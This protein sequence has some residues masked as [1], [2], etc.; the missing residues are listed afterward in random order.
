MQSENVCD[1]QWLQ[2]CGALPSAPPSGPPQPSE[3]FPCGS[4]PWH[5]VADLMMMMMDT[6][7]REAMW[8]TFWFL[9]E[10]R[11]ELNVHDS[12]SFQC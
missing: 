2:D 9:G 12:F 1:L 8:L 4:K 10:G 11:S 5:G 6:L 7:H 3:I